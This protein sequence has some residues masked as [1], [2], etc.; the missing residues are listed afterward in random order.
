MR[1]LFLS[2]ARN[3]AEDDEGAAELNDYFVSCVAAGRK[4]WGS[5]SCWRP[6]MVLV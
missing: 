4:A 5:L 6:G 3:G 2:M 1:D